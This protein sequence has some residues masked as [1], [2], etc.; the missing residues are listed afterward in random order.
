MIIKNIIIIKII[1]KI[2]SAIK[3]SVTFYRYKMI[4]RNKTNSKRHIYNG[5]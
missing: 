1:L 3:E 4:L 5:F 2:I